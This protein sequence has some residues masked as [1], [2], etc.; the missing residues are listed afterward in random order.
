MVASNLQKGNKGKVRHTL[1]KVLIS[2]SKAVSPY[3]EIPLLSMTHDQ[4]NIRPTVTSQL[5][6]V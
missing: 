3:V 4:C 1:S 5:A 6:P 2:L